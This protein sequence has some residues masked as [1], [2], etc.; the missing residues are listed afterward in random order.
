MDKR[1]KLV[2]LYHFDRTIVGEGSGVAAVAEESKDPEGGIQ[3]VA[4]DVDRR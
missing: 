4:M 2:P 1:A 3:K